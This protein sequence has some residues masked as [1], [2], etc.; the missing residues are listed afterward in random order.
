MQC[1]VHCQ[2]F[3]NLLNDMFTFVVAEGYALWCSAYHAF[4]LRHCYVHLLLCVLLL[5]HSVKAL[6]MLTL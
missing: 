4:L 1:Y 3:C 5:M 6:A 2:E